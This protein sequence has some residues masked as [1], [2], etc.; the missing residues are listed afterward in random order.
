[1][2]LFTGDTQIKAGSLHDRFVRMDA[3]RPRPGRR[4]GLRF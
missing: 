1:M 2:L 4:S 3:G